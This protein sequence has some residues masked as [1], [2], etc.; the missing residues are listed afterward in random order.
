MFGEGF[1][2]S[3]GGVVGGVAGWV[4][5]AL[6]GA[7]DDDGSGLTL[8]AKGGK[9]GRNAVDDAEEVRIHYL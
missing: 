5:N 9:K 6:F 1:D 7:G 3:F 4:R 2:S 8:R